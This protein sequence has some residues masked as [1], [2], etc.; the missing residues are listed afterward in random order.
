MNR[1]VGIKRREKRLYVT[2]SLSGIK[3]V[4]IRFY[5]PYPDQK[6]VGIIKNAI[7][8]KD[9]SAPTGLGGGCLE[10]IFPNY[11]L[12]ANAM[13]YI[14]DTDYKQLEITGIYDEEAFKESGIELT[15]LGK[16]RLLFY[17]QSENMTVIDFEIKS[18]LDEAMDTMKM[19]IALEQRTWNG[20]KKLFSYTST[21]EV[22]TL[23]SFKHIEDYFNDNP[24]PEMEETGKAIA[25][26]ETIEEFVKFKMLHEEQIQELIDAGLIKGTK[27][28]SAVNGIIQY[29][30]II[31]SSKKYNPLS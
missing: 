6:I 29:K 5:A 30:D 14:Y 26:V 20:R 2:V 4:V 28:P 3:E 31:V 18:T 16:K 15:K 24:S 11:E 13:K 12:M 19:E 27:S 25:S 8:H 17:T 7:N 1:I 23:V 21:D 10:E 9:Y 22:I